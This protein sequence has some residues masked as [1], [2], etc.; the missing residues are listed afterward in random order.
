MKRVDERIGTIDR[1]KDEDLANQKSKWHS[2]GAS[3]LAQSLVL[4]LGVFQSFDPLFSQRLSSRNLIALGTLV[5]CLHSKI[6]ATKA[7][8]ICIE[9]R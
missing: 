5:H 8:I 3:F 4:W 2:P 1:M 9:L 7:P 6:M